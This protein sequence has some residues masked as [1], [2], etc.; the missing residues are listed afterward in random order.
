MVQSSKSRIKIA[1]IF[2]AIFAAVSVAI[3]YLYDPSDGRWFPK[4]PT[5]LLTGGYDCPS[6]GAQRALHAA[7]H[8]D[9]GAALRYNYFLV[10]GVP[11]FLVAL[12][13][14]CGNGKVSEWINR[15]L[16]TR[17]MIYIYLVLYL[18]WWPI[19]NILGI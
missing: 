12:V 5:K 11:Y 14:S 6:C 7:L 16:L 3:Y 8:G 4:C 19:R 15:H 1:V 13:A 10:I 17:T 2:L 18:A 9:F